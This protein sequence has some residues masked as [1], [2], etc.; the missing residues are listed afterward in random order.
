ME[1]EEALLIANSV[2]NELEPHCFRCEVV[3]SVKRRKLEPT[4]IDIVC[5]PKPYDFGLLESGIAEVVNQWEMV[6]GKMDTKCK[7][8][9]RIL[10]QGVKLDLWMCTPENWGYMVALKT[11]SKRFNKFKILPGYK[12]MGYKSIKGYLYKYDKMVPVY[13]EEDLFEYCGIEWVEPWDRK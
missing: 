6:K 10:P 13:E 1:Y 5:I 3:G 12:R 4:D 2:M 8:T 9:Q 11:G 7:Q